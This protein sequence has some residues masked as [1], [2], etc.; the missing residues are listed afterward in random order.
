MI[1]QDEFHFGF[2]DLADDALGCSLAS[3][4][5]VLSTSELFCSFQTITLNPL[6]LNTP[7]LTEAHR[8][9]AYKIG[10]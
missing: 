10:P 2:V 4:S 8:H 1:S 7:Q 6:Y 3:A 9:E 5:S